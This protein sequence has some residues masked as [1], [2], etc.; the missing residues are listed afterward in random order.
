MSWDTLLLKFQGELEKHR[1]TINFNK[2]KHFSEQL[3]NFYLLILK[4]LSL[5]T[6]QILTSFVRFFEL[7]KRASELSKIISLNF[8]LLNL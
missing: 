8:I 1:V 2:L 6:L 3:F 7:N 4:L 5:F